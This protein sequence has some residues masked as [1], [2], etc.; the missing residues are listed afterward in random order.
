MS[1]TPAM[2]D[3]SARATPSDADPRDRFARCLSMHGGPLRRT[4]LEVLQ[5]NVGRLCNQT[6]RHCHVNAGPRR[7]EL[8]SQE[9]AELCVALLDGRP[10]IHTLD[11]TGGAPEMA[12]PFR[13][14]VE[15]GRRRGKRVIDR[16]NLTILTEPGH[17][18][19][20]DFLAAH[21][22]EIVA[23]LPCYTAGNVDRQRGDGVFERSI[24]GLRMLNERSYGAGEG[25]DSACLRRLSLVFN[26]GGASLPPSQAKLEADYRLRLKE[27]FGIVFDRLICIANMPIGRFRSDLQRAGQL[28]AYVDKLQASFNPATLPG[29]MCRNTLSVDYEGWLHDCDFNQMLGLPLGG[30]RRHLR[31]LH[32]GAEGMAIATGTHC[33]GCAAGSGSSCGGA[34]V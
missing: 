29:L 11:I 21:D 25:S 33:L 27:D 19:L 7:R 34:V 2:I 24:A 16:C 14:L 23:S 15:E 22:V 18:D 1:A 20:A 9:V 12:P 32:D 6:C 5:V 4:A 30:V 26:P 13:F 8:M 28:G 3:E 31:E 17:E 10:S